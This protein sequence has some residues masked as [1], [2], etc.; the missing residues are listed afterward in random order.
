ML[1]YHREGAVA[2]LSIRRAEK[3][4]A[5][6]ETMWRSLLSHCQGI[7]AETVTDHHAAPR[8][9]LL[10]GQPGAFCAGADIEEMQTLMQN[11][12]ALAA[13]NA[14]VAQAQLA[15]EQ[16][17]L[18]TI[19]VIDGPASA[20]RAACSPSHRRGWV[21]STASKTRGVWW[22]YSGHRAPNVC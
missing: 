5:F 3:K 12:A 7:A 10:Q 22:R 1:D 21:C 14:V 16:L 8:V 15:L 2:T 18:A 20:P 11:S 4:N 17:P 9:L 6:N 13:N 19:A